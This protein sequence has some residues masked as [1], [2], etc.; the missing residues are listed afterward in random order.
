MNMN[1]NRNGKLGPKA[2]DVLPPLPWQLSN[3]AQISK[4]EKLGSAFIRNIKY[5]AED[6]A[7]ALEE[8]KRLA[9]MRMRAEAL[10]YGEGARQGGVLDWHAIT[11]QQAARFDGERS[12][13]GGAGQPMGLNGIS[14]NR[15]QDKKKKQH[16]LKGRKFDSDRLLHPWQRQ[17]E[18]LKRAAGNPNM[19]IDAAKLQYNSSLDDESLA[20]ERADQLHMRD[21]DNAHGYAVRLKE[22]ASGK[23]KSTISTKQLPPLEPI[24]SKLANISDVSLSSLTSVKNGPNDFNLVSPLRTKSPNK[25]VRFN[26]KSHSFEASPD[27]SIKAQRPHQSPKPKVMP[28]S[29]T[30][31]STKSKSVAQGLSSPPTFRAKTEPIR[32]GDEDDDDEDEDNEGIGWSPFV[33]PINNI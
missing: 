19:D 21:N 11:G 22:K 17:L 2:G 29:T 26:D 15:R 14:E 33:I 16:S 9:E 12:R 3:Q 23:L 7:S 10:K 28:E 18:S 8:E 24:S 20:M 1:M 30:A 13:S 5:K 4:Y 32:Y 6:F 25:S 27:A 31:I